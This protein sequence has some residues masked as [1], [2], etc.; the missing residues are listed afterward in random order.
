MFPISIQYLSALT[1]AIQSLELQQE[2]K[3]VH[4]DVNN[5]TRQ[6][7]RDSVPEMDGTVYVMASHSGTKSGN[8]HRQGTFQFTRMS[9]AGEM[10]NIGRIKESMTGYAQTLDLAGKHERQRKPRI[11]RVDHRE[12]DLF[13]EQMLRGAGYTVE[14][15]GMLIGDYGWDIR[16]ESWLGGRGYVNAILERKTLAD[17][18]DTDRLKDQLHRMR[19]RVA[20]E[21][22]SARSLFVVLVEHQFDTDTKRKWTEEAVA[23]AKLSIQLTGV[24]VTECEANDVAGKLDSLYKWTQKLGHELAS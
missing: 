3:Y 1:D 5:G 4:I 2:G 14:R 23:N 12:P 18:R 11:I 15:I 21:P 19:A 20:V 7:H 13:T 22:P 24:L 8:G 6:C 17:L 16:E 9:T 10:K